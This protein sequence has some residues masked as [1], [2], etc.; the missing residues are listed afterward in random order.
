MITES[1]MTLRDTKPH[2]L[3]V[4]D[5]W[6]LMNEHRS[7]CTSICLH[8]AV[9]LRGKYRPIEP[10]QQGKE[11]QKPIHAIVLPLCGSMHIDL[12]T[13]SPMGSVIVLQ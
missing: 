9:V 6:S 11:L 2:S 12:C 10:G 5:S 3:K 7:T 1:V 8:A 4:T 13:I